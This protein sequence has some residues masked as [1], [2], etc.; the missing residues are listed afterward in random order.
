MLIVRGLPLALI[1]AM[2]AGRTIVSTLCGVET[3]IRDGEIGWLAPVGDPAGLAAS[4]T[5]A[6]R[7][8]DEALRRAQ[9]AQS[10]AWQQYGQNAMLTAYQAL[11][12]EVRGSRR[13]QR[14]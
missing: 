14:R 3:V 2:A 1:Q 4:V 10:V 13:T 8:R 9:K 12:E 7:A 11:Y 5:A 6:L